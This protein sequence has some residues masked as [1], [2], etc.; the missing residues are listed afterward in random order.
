[1]KVLVVNG[2]PRG[3]QGNTERIL[4]PFLAGVVDAG[5]ETEVIYLKE[6]KINHCLGCFSCWSKTPG[7]CVHQDDMPELLPKIMVADMLVYATPLYYYTMTGLMKNFIDRKLPLATL[8]IQEHDGRY[9]HN[10]R[11][12]GYGSKQTVLISNCGFP[13]AY[14]FSG[15]VET[16][17]VMT[18]GCLSAAILSAQGG[19]FGNGDFQEKLDP[20][21]Q[22]IRKAG[23][24]VVEYGHIT[25]ETQA[26]IDQ[27]IISPQVY[28]ERVNSNWASM[29]G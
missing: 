16:F 17:K 9:T 18:K 8:A 20:F 7:V 25:P 12:A 13:G 21:F 23:Q 2:S 22:G 6:K 1:M 3:R 5:A 24:E 11:N 28:I 14:N 10:P 19:I 29:G 26:I 27:D 4:Q 15:L